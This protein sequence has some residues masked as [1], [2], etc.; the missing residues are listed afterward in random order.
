MFDF[1]IIIFSSRKLCAFQK[2]TP[3]IIYTIL[4]VF[5]V[6]E[7]IYHDDGS[8]CNGILL[9]EKL[10]NVNFPGQRANKKKLIYFSS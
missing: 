10:L 1:I 5:K 8:V 6:T 9:Y 4:K 7:Y 3:N 2:H